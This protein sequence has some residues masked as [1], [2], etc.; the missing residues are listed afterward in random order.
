MQKDVKDNG[1]GVV[2]GYF[3]NAS[4]DSWRIPLFW[5]RVQ[6]QWIYLDRGARG[7]RVDTACYSLFRE[8]DIK[9]NDATCIEFAN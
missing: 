1:G 8:G 9:K 3:R 6:I 2:Y 7:D 4:R 5:C